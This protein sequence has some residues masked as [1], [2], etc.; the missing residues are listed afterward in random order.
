VASL[1]PIRKH[2]LSCFYRYLFVVVVSQ[3][4]VSAT[5]TNNDDDD[6]EDAN[7]LSALLDEALKVILIIR[8][9]RAFSHVAL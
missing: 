5:T 9:S 3:S 7:E 6:D 2:L 4:N 8:I 1:Q